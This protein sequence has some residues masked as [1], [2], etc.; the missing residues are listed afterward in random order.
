[1]AKAKLESYRL[2][3]NN[4]TYSD[5]SSTNIT[6]NTNV[7]ISV[8]FEQVRKKIEDMTSLTNDQTDEILDK[9]NEIETVVNSKDKKK[10]NGKK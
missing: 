7:N 9:I 10:I 2:G 5:S 1:M 8:T 3:L 6:V 4:I